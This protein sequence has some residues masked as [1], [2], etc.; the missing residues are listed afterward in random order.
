MFALKLLFPLALFAAS[1]QPEALDR[2]KTQ[3][4]SEEQSVVVFDLDDTLINTKERTHRV[5][6]EFAGSVSD[7]YPYEAS[8]LK[9]LQVRD[10]RYVL[11]ETLA[12]LGIVNEEFLKEASAFWAPR[13]F[14]DRYV[15]GDKP[16]AGAAAYVRSLDREGAQIV[17]L[18][19]RDR[20][21]MGKGTEEN[22]RRL[23]FP[24]GE[25]LMKPDAKMD[26]FSFKQSAIEHIRELGQI[27]GV[28]ENEPA[29]LNLL[30]EA[31]PDAIGVFVDTI[32]SPKPDRP[33]AGAAWV[34]DFLQDR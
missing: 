17:Y 25:L 5:L 6:R 9:T 34:G 3:V 29:N 12:Q 8:R 23:G 24:K 20:P 14:S 28:F 10:T 26:D 31:F 30:H 19:G 33:Y 21:N 2:V 32:H 7:R 18:T 1:Y 4:Q 22:L 13:F 16:I 11:K 27:V 15:L